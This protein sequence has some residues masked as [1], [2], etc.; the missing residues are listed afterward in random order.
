MKWWHTLLAVIVLCH[1]RLLRRIN[2]IIK[3]IKELNR[4]ID[5]IGNGSDK[6]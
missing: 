1:L 5:R 3:K 4:L 6:T 2:R